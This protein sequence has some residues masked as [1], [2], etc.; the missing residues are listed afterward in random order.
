[1]LGLL[2]EVVDREEE[3]DERLLDHV[4]TFSSSSSSGLS[5]P[6]LLAAGASR[7]K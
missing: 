6:P 7:G 1:M 2:R 4:E 5:A 3:V